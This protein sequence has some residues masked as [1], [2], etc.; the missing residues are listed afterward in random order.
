[1]IKG[2][3][4]LASKLDVTSFMRPGSFEF[5]CNCQVKARLAGPSNNSGSAVSERRSDPVRAYDWRVC[6]TRLIEVVVQFR[7]DRS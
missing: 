6:E 2:I 7:F 5:F 3:E 4:E 1:M